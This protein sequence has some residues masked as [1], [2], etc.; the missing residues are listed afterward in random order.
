MELQWN[1]MELK[2][3]TLYP[4]TA[5]KQ[6]STETGWITTFIHTWIELDWYL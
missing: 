4:M 1:T 2:P 3:V 5:V 6:P